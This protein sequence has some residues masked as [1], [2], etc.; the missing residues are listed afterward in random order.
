MIKLSDKQKLRLN[1]NKSSGAVNSL[2]PKK[3]LAAL[4]ASGSL[5]SSDKIESYQADLNTSNYENNGLIEIDPSYIQNWNF[6]DRP[7]NELGDIVE[8][9]QDIK[10]NG[11]IQPCIVRPIK[12]STN[13][14]ELIVGERRW[15]AA[16]Y[17][18]FN[19]KIIVKNLS[20]KEAILV[21]YS[22][23]ENRTNLSDYAKG[24]HYEKIIKNKLITRSDLAKNI[25]K[26]EA[27]VR[28][29]L[30]FSKLDNSLKD[31]VKDFSKISSRTASEMLRWQKKGDVYLKILIANAHVLRKGDIGEKKLALLISNNIN[32]K[33]PSKRIEI[34][35]SENKTVFYWKENNAGSIS[36]NFSSEYSKKVNKSILEDFILNN[37]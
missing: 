12:D 34:K 7:E 24:I 10:L 13:K 4:N 35:N 36:I 26:S 30:S 1:K 22:E 20:D 8:L 18:N 32:K 31:A 2:A 33:L 3:G 28:Q 29:M 16:K 23:N 19:L 25:N 37:L 9:A 5:I 15:R 27:Y 14:Y 17:G 6:S 21:Q 11:Q